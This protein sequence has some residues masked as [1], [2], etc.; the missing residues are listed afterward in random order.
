MGGGVARASRRVYNI[1]T[2][3]DMKYGVRN[4]SCVLAPSVGGTDGG[5]GVM[6]DKATCIY[7]YTYEYMAAAAA[8]YEGTAAVVDRDAIDLLSCRR[9]KGSG[10]RGGTARGE[11]RAAE[12]RTDRPAMATL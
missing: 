7:V 10:R 5:G 11:R 12:S 3:Y 8:A 4:G 1:I 6:R 2:L 9:A